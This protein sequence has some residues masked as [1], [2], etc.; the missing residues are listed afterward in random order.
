MGRLP[1][2]HVV[3]NFQNGKVIKDVRH[4]VICQ[5][6]RHRPFRGQLNKTTNIKLGSIDVFNIVYLTFLF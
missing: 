2:Y 3:H 4:S 1:Y 6:V 5:Y